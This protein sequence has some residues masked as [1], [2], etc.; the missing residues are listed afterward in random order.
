MLD[1]KHKNI[2][3][4]SWNHSL[5]P[6]IPPSDCCLAFCCNTQLSALSSSA[7]KQKK[8]INMFQLFLFIYYWLVAN[9]SVYKESLSIIISV[10][11][12]NCWCWRAGT[13][14][15]SSRRV[16]V[17][18]KKQLFNPQ[19]LILVVVFHSTSSMFELVTNL[20][21]GG[22][23]YPVWRGSSWLEWRKSSIVGQSTPVR[24][25]CWLKRCNARKSIP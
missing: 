2:F 1:K 17:C 23:F 24:Q 19:K 6:Y 25:C 9:P 10:A 4:A 11:G 3:L 14:K 20:F 16:S 13:R 22:T 12:W 18:M 5:H 15:R 21:W 8:I 7:N